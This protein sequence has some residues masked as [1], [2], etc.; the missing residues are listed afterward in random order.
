ML[1][2]SLG[3]VHP[4]GID[5][6]WYSLNSFGAFLDLVFAETSHDYCMGILQGMTFIISLPGFGIRL[7]REQADR[8]SVV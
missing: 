7:R 2:G 5:T 3:Y 4:F 1:S 8:K 6:S